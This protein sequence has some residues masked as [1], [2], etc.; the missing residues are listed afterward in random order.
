VDK[1]GIDGERD[2]DVIGAKIHFG[3]K[4]QLSKQFTVDMMTGI[5]K[6]KYFSKLE[7]H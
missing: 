3:L 6:D 2:I 4:L 5:N 1:D 7:V